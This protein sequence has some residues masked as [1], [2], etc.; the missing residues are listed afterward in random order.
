MVL[1]PDRDCVTVTLADQETAL[2]ALARLL[3]DMQQPPTGD[4]IA[5]AVNGFTA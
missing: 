3:N 2:P 4:D 5:N 1:I